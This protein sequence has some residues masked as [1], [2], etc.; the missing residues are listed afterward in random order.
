MRKHTD[1]TLI[2]KALRYANKHAEFAGVH[3]Y[4]MVTDNHIHLNCLIDGTEIMDIVRVYHTNHID[5]CNAI[6]I[7]GNAIYR[8]EYSEVNP[9]KYNN[10][11]KYYKLWKHLRKR[12][13]LK[14]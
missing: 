6:Y 13:L 14:S 10:R 1:F 7:L 8:Y 3:F 9:V 12:E 4:V 5:F 2:A 11:Y